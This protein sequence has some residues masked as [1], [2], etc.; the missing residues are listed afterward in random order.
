MRARWGR[1]ALLPMALLLMQGC[2][3]KW[4][5]RAAQPPLALQWPYQPA[6]AKVSYVESLSGF[7]QKKGSASAW[8]AVVYG[9]G[10]ENPNSFVLPVGVA[11]G[12]DGRLAVADLGRQ[13]VHLF[14][15]ARQSYLRLAGSKTEKIVSPVGVAFDDDLN[16]YVS[17]SAGK[18]FAFGVE[19]QLRFTLEKAG[20]EPL[21]RP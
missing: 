19:G 3:V 14:L 21:Q 4:T 2:A 1:W 15:P 8:H 12:G 6:R 17:D 5:M 10:K 11:V 16:L 13:C 18:V 9:G 20:E 7:A